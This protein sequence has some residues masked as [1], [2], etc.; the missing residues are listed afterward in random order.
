MNTPN[1]THTA[2]VD[3][4]GNITPEWRVLITQLLQELQINFGDNGL[5]VPQQ[6]TTNITTLEPD[7]KNGTLLYDSDTDELK[8]RLNDGT[9][10]TIQTL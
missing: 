4:N 1:Y 8:V 3:K 7:S 10:H 6:T 9:F 2:L 5:V